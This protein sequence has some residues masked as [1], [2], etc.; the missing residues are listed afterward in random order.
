[1]VVNHQWCKVR[2]DEIEL[3]SGEIIDDYFITV[4][5]DVVQ[6]LAVTNDQEIVLVRQYRHGAN[7]IMLELPAGA[8]YPDEESPQTA[9]IRELREETGYFAETITPLAV[10]HDNPSKTTHKVHL[11][12]AENAIKVGP[13]QLDI[14]EEIDVVLVPLEAVMEKIATGEICVSGSVAT[15]FLG[16]DFFRNRPNIS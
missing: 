16:L 12:V 5:P 7:E 10:L 1:M 11:F 8:F 2:Q 3:P 4:G 15:I 9:A 14:T 13:Q 6:I